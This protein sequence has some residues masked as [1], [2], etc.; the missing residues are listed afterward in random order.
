MTIRTG[1]YVKCVMGANRGENVLRE[2]QVYQVSEVDSFG[3]L[4]VDGHDYPWLA[5]RFEFVSGSEVRIKVG[6]VWASRDKSDVVEILAIF[7]RNG[8]K[9]ASYIYTKGKMCGI[10]SHRS[11]SEMEKKFPVF[12]ESKELVAC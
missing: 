1:D 4:C 3:F 11:M 9:S 7:Y 6:D 12:V 10:A 5:G 2:G 8:I